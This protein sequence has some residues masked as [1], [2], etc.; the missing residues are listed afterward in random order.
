MTMAKTDTIKPQQIKPAQTTAIATY[1]DWTPEQME[2]EAKEMGGGGAWWKPP[3]GTTVVRLL[4]PKIGW[5]SP[6]VI[7]HQHFIRM[8][9]VDGAV[10][11]C[12]PKM[13]ESKTCLAC[14]KSE[15][16][17]ASGNARS[18]RAA[19]DL[20]P[21]KRMMTNIVVNPK[22]AQSKVQVWAFGR[23]VYDQLKAIRENDE[24]GG[25]FID[26]I[27]G[28]NL[29]VKRVGTG[30]DDTKYTIIPSR[31]ASGLV[32]MEWIDVQTDLRRMI[33]IP[34]TEQQ[35]RLLEG[36]DPRDVWSD[37]ASDAK[38][39]RRAASAKQAG[40]VVDATTVETRTAED[41][42]FEDEVD[43]D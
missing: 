19:R 4:P 33:R 41:D 43:L 16:L 25:N 10:I 2:E 34:T 5:K 39:G 40:D 32:N 20:R 36:E 12:C 6:F 15:Q 1:G 9:G 13:H 11:F 17:E 8:P 29:G 7:Q 38:E 21:Q 14:A 30:K 35:A 18:E 23:T 42:L 3:V 22:D 27:S 26:P 31:T 37:D 24:G 28:F